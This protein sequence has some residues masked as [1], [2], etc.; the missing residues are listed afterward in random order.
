VIIESEDISRWKFSVISAD[1]I[2]AAVEVGPFILITPPPRR[3]FA[4][5]FSVQRH[6]VRPYE[7][8]Y[9]LHSKQW[10]YFPPRLLSVLL[11]GVVITKNKSLRGNVGNTQNVLKGGIRVEHKRWKIQ[12]STPKL[13]TSDKVPWTRSHVSGLSF[14]HQR[15]SKNTSPTGLPVKVHFQ[16]M[17]LRWH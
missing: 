10:L 12:P 14:S 6:L 17:R 5:V 9:V 16:K 1:V 3:K 11:P 13:W 7:T 4:A 2:K 15:N 8:K